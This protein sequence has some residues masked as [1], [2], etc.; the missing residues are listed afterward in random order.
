MSDEFTVKL[1]ND[2]ACSEGWA[3]REQGFDNKTNAL[4]MAGW[5]IATLGEAFADDREATIHVVEQARAESPLHI[6]TL[7]LLQRTAPE[8]YVRAIYAAHG[9]PIAP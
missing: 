3:L 2:N 7:E 1:I 9:T 6:M 4:G 8:S 5:R